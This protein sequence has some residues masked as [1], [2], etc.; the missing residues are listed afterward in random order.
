MNFEAWEALEDPSKQ[1][2]ALSGVCEEIKCNGMPPFPYRLVHERLQLNPLE[3]ASVCA[4]SQPFQK[5][6]VGSTWIP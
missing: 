1:M 6:L 3:V 2:T 4:W 5:N